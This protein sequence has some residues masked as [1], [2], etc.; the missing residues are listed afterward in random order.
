MPGDAPANEVDISKL[1]ASVFPYKKEQSARNV[2]ALYGHP[3]KDRYRYA[4][5]W[6]IYRE[7]TVLYLDQCAWD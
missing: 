6:T 1:E 2:Q 7:L 3:G 5:V 4:S